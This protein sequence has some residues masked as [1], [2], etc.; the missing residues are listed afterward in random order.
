M[1][2][3]R[4]SLFLIV[5][6]LTDVVSAQQSISETDP[7]VERTSLSAKSGKLLYANPASNI[8]RYRSSMSRLEGFY[9]LEDANQPIV[10]QLGDGHHIAGFHTGAYLHFKNNSLVWGEAEYQ[11]G[12]RKNVQW[13]ETSDFMRVYPYVT[14][15]TLGGDFDK[16]S[17]FFKGGYAQKIGR[18]SYGADMSYSS[19]LEHREYDPRP[20]NNTVYI[21]ATVG[22]SYHTH[23]DYQLGGYVYAEKYTQTQ[24]IA[25][26]DPLGSIPVYHMHGLGM[27]YARFAGSRPDAYYTGRTFRVGATL[28]PQ[29]TTGWEAAV[30][31]EN[32]HLQKQLPALNDAPINDIAEWKLDA[33]LSWKQKSYFVNLNG[34]FSSRKGKERIYDDGVSNWKEISS[35]E[36]YSAKNMFAELK[37]GYE[38]ILARQWNF[39][40]L[41]SVAFNRS[42]IDY[43]PS[44]K[45]VIGGVNSTLAGSFRY[46]K[47]RHFLTLDLAGSYYANCMAE[48]SISNPSY[49]KYAN[50]MVKHNY[51]MLTA[52]FWSVRTSAAY[53]YR[54]NKWINTVYLKASFVH[55]ENNKEYH[56]NGFTAT[57]GLTI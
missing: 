38:W 42:Q 37:G 16:E 10:M 51:E 48:Q 21:S 20:K 53:H 22:A 14:A 55:Q 1:L 3:Y 12:K 47:G 2:T 30:Q 49:F 34:Y 36:P 26:L 15:D 56:A 25:F 57:L 5:L 8:L 13:S 54:M 44:R 7:L 40:V 41:P 11:N 24:D 35:T 50:K 19:I 27:H 45:Q 28:Q 39:Q 29:N 46:S 23:F 33:E 32:Y 6:A 4:N 43:K 52:D 31:M 9:S 18:W 17:Y